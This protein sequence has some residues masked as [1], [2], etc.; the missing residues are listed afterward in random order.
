MG[1][2][3]ILDDDPLILEGL[4]MALSDTGL[5]V[6]CTSSPF[7]LPF[8]LRRERPDVALIDLCMPSLKG[9]R[10]LEA[11]TPSLRGG[12]HFVIFSG[13]VDT[14]LGVLAAENGAVDFINKGDELEAILRRIHFWVG[15]SSGRP[16]HHLEPHVA[17]VTDLADSEA[18]I[19]LRNGGYLVTRNAPGQMLP[20]GVNAVVIDA[21][22]DGAVQAWRTLKNG[23]VPVVVV[24]RTSVLFHPAATLS[25]LAV[26]RDLISLIDRRIAQ[27]IRRTRPA[28]AVD[29]V[30]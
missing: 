15:Q 9:E 3:L 6:T 30:A 29:C 11:L 27:A 17:V 5:E 2:V 16:T 4:S 23:A 21:T 18:A 24:T 1:K 14:D 10:V 12:T 20:G 7:E 28:P 25:P 26:R 22:R 8:L 19:T 13:R